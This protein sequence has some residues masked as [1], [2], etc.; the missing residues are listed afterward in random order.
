MTAYRASRAPDYTGAFLVCLGVL[1]FAAFFAVWALGGFV[2][3]LASGL[4]PA[5]LLGRLGPAPN[6]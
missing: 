1:A 5:F 3:A 6:R 2:L 4:G